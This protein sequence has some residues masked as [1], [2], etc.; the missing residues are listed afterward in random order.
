LTKMLPT[1]SANLDARLA[2]LALSA[3]D[4]CARIFCPNWICS[5]AAFGIF[6]VFMLMFEMHRW[7]PG[8]KWI[9]I[10][11]NFYYQIEYLHVERCTYIQV[12]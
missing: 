3:L 7:C 6:F 4:S 10:R 11:A 9:E 2:R 5:N 8:R 12:V 1:D